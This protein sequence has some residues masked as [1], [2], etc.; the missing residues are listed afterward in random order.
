M[1]GRMRGLF[2]DSL[3]NSPVMMAVRR[4][5]SMRLT[6]MLCGRKS[7]SFLA[8]AN[9]AATM[10]AAAGGQSAVRDYLFRLS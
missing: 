3:Q 4:Y 6:R 9:L 2:R 7:E 8:K 5:A 1:V 10:T